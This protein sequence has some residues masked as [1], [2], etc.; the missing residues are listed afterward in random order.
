MIKYNNPT[1]R[2]I[3]ESEA[4]L[5]VCPTNLIGDMSGGVSK[6]FKDK[7][8]KVAA[9][10]LRHVNNHILGDHPATFYTDNSLLHFQEA[11]RIP[12][13]KVIC[14]LVVHEHP[15][16]HA[17]VDR[18]LKGLARLDQF[19]TSHHVN[20]V[21]IPALGCG[22]GGLS[23]DGTVHPLLLKW[24]EEAEFSLFNLTTVE[25]YPPYKN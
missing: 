5:L 17:E 4:Q 8:P 20:H 6:H 11:F 10:Y 18:I 21:A 9:R 22:L 15:G 14:L 23:W 7:F 12:G 3:L 16:Q 25:L 24:V 2:N 13:E 1:G 19:I